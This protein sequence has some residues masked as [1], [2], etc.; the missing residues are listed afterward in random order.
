MDNSWESQM[1]QDDEVPSPDYQRRNQNP[2]P[3]RK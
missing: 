1:A 3:A 2:K